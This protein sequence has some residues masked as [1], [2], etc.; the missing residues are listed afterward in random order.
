MRILAPLL[1]ALTAALVLAGAADLTRRP[2]LG[3]AMR[4]DQ[5][6]AV[7]PGS[8]AARAGLAVDDRIQR[9]FVHRPGD[10]LGVR[11]EECQPAEISTLPRGTLAGLLVTPPAGSPARVVSFELIAPPLGENLR[12]WLSL[13]VALICLGTGYLTWHLR[14]GGMSRAFLFIGLALALILRPPLPPSP[15]WLAALDPLLSNL[16]GLT[17]AAA[18]VEFVVRL[19]VGR[20]SA[21]ARPFVLTAWIIS[22]LLALA[23]IGLQLPLPVSESAEQVVSMAALLVIV[24]CLIGALFRLLLTLARTRDRAESLRLRVVLW[25]GIV[26][27]TPIT[28]L[29]ILRNLTRLPVIPGEQFAVL[30]VAFLP[31][32]WM[33]AIVRHRIFDIRLLLRRG[34]VAFLVTTVLA[35]IWLA[36]VTW[37]GPW[38]DPARGHPVVAA[39]GLLLAAFLFSGT[40]HVAQAFVDRTLFRADLSRRRRL[41][42]LS[43][44]ISGFLD[45][46]RLTE[47]LVLE[48]DQRLGAARSSI[49]HLSRN[50]KVNGVPTPAF[51]A[52]P[53]AEVLEQIDRP[54]TRADILFRAPSELKAVVAERLAECGWELFVPIRDGHALQA[55][56]VFE[57]AREAGGLDSRELAVL[58]R[59]SRSA[60]EA[61]AQ[62]RRN[63]DEHERERLQGELEVARGIQRHLLPDEPPLS[64][65]VELAGVTLPGEAVGGDA[66]DFLRLSDGRLGVAV[67]DVSG[68]G[69]PAAILMASVQASFRALAETDI[70]PAALMAAL[71]RRVLEI[72]EPDRFVCFF[73]AAIDPV[74]GE[75]AYVNA[76]IEPP[77]LIGADGTVKDLEEGGIILGVIPGATYESG[78]VRVQPGDVLLVFSD[79]LVDARIPEEALTDRHHLVDMV[80]RSPGA[81]ADQIKATIMA[82]AQPPDGT[83]SDDDVT[84]VVARF[85]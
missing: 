59:I 15:T 4:A 62:A 78:R 12:R 37:L 67:S 3:F 38:L 41:E 70:E 17:L 42:E 65:L 75:L 66:H 27:L 13:L 64:P 44:R 54:A 61:L 43:G 22:M 79:G 35:S 77:L 57:L 9:V 8:P 74:A 55:V 56:A 34:A 11:I 25:G 52:S 51:L 47:A 18:L 84:L 5:V 31:L 49:L 46:T 72:N 60:S 14:P 40:R 6:A 82:N 23:A 36:A 68:K 24:S 71:N 45:S 30:A 16:A 53:L 7:D 76:G 19:P 21:A 33:Y 32:C 39:L 81:S 63:E 83:V 80:R 58:R 1:A 2:Y 73:Y 48:L 69:I 50:G 10:S 28:L 20:L 85:Y 26:G 29:L